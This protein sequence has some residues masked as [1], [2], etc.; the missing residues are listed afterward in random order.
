MTAAS[1]AGV[2]AAMAHLCAEGHGSGAQMHIRGVYDSL[3]VLHQD[4]CEMIRESSPGSPWMWSP[5]EYAMHESAL[6]GLITFARSARH[7]AVSR[8]CVELLARTA[9]YLAASRRVVRNVIKAEKEHSG[10]CVSGHVYA[11]LR[12]RANRSLN[13]HWSYVCVTYSSI[14]ASS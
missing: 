8:A 3:L 6:S 4:N 5:V 2:F 14:A 7:V 12:H 1:L 11:R 13:R 9:S 10:E